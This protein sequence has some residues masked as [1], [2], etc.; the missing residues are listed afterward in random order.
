MAVLARWWM[1]FSRIS[2][3]PWMCLQAAIEQILQEDD[4]LKQESRLLKWQ[5]LKNSELLNVSFIGTLIASACTGSIQW[6]SLQTAHWIVSAAWYGTLVFSL[7][8]VMVAFYLSILLSNFSINPSGP[9]LLLQ[10]LHR[11]GNKRKAR[12]GSLFALQLPLM[13][14]SYSLIAYVIG[15]AVMVVQP[16]WSEPWG[17]KSLIAIFFLIFLTLSIGGFGAVCQFIY[18]Q[19]EEVLEVE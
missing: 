10:T 13:L 14:L 12:W 2:T 15:L 8:S 17:D 4:A 19:C 1:I 7:M 9:K 16:L 6:S 18:V 3:M 5:T 11:S